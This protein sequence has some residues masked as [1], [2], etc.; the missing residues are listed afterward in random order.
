[1]Q[2]GYRLSE[3]TGV[4]VY[5]LKIGF[6]FRGFASFSRR[7]RLLFG[8]KGGWHQ[9]VRSHV[10]LASVSISCSTSM[11][12]TL[13]T[14]ILSFVLT[15]KDLFV[16]SKPLRRKE[17]RSITSS[18]SGGFLAARLVFNLFFYGSFTL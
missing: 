12:S 9:L 18:S 15:A 8:R 4:V 7:E 17:E 6:V 2:Q 13:A 11:V 5:L 14:V 3:F 16:Q 1:M 10:L